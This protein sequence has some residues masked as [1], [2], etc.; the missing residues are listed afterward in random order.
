V[1][2]L[3][4]ELRDLQGKCLMFSMFSLCLADISLVVLQ[5]HSHNLSNTMCVT[6]GTA[7]TVVYFMN[8]SLDILK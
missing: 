2:L 1:Y 7:F 6:Q 8:I 3:V 4:P 5:L